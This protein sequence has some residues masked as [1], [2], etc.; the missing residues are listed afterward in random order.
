MVG[1]PTK[2]V[3][4][5]HI[6]EDDKGLADLKNICSKSGLNIKDASINSSNPNDAKN[7]AYIKSGILALS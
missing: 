6:H 7:E 2:N 4:I 1:D 5:S 3:Y